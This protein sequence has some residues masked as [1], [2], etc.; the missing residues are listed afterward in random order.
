MITPQEQRQLRMIEQ[1][2]ELDDPLL[3]KALREGLNRRF[4][5]RTVIIA[6]ASLLLLLGIVAS[7]VALIL[8]AAV[9]YTIA[10]SVHLAR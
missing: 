10:L 1:R 5:L 2:L 8:A 6:V 9:A 4:P 7:S 3:A